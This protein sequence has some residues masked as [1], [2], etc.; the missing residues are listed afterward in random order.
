MGEL[1]RANVSKY[2]MC[3]LAFKAENQ[4]MN[5]EC[6]KV[7]WCLFPF[8]MMQQEAVRRCGLIHSAAGFL[9]PSGGR[10]CGNFEYVASILSTTD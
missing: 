5:T 9:N 6:R 4:T 10:G 1:N 3:P 2:L 7:L 8:L